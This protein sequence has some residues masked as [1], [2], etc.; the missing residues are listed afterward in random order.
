[1]LKITLMRKRFVS[2]TIHA[3]LDWSRFLSRI[4]NKATLC[5]WRGSVSWLLKPP[6]EVLENL[7]N[8]NENISRMGVFA[9]SVTLIISSMDPF[10]LTLYTRCSQFKCYSEQVENETVTIFMCKTRQVSNNSSINGRI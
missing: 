1:M 4:Y 9:S 3:L 5:V 8:N 7:D 10:V 2:F 6:P